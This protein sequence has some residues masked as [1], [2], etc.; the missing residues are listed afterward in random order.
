[1]RLGGKP[2]L[3]LLAH[4]EPQPLVALALL[5]HE[6]EQVRAWG[7]IRL[8]PRSTPI[9]AAQL[10]HVMPGSYHTQQLVS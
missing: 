1:M 10:D 3:H 9:L 2:H 5:A 7:H 8:S 4:L 6:G